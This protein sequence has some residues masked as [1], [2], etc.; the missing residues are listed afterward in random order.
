MAICYTRGV[1]LA[2]FGWIRDWCIVKMPDGEVVEDLPSKYLVNLLDALVGYK[3]KAKAQGLE[4]APHWALWML[5]A[6]ISNVVKCDRLIEMLWGQRTDRS[7]DSLH[8]A[9][10]EGCMVQ[11]KNDLPSSEWLPCKLYSYC[12]FCES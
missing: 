6:Q 9:M 8:M 7:S 3:D 12:L 4:G 10:D 2:V 5:K 1:V 11:W